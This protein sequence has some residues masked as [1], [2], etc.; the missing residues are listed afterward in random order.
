MSNAPNAWRDTALAFEL[1]AMRVEYVIRLLV[2]AGHVTQEKVDAAFDIARD[3]KAASLVQGTEAT[4]GGGATQGVEA[5]Y[6]CN[7]TGKVGDDPEGRCAACNPPDGV[8]G[9]DRGQ[10]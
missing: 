1:R 3:F 2:A 4:A 6:R 5:C 10:G 7:D 9:L 8:M